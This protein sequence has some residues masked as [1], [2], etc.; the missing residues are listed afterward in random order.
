MSS[1]GEQKDVEF[2]KELEDA[3]ADNTKVVEFYGNHAKDYN[4]T[5]H[6]MGY[7]KC[8]DRLASLLKEHLGRALFMYLFLF[9]KH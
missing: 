6:L 4:D 2:F 9:F 5:L 3:R 1:A 8:T 7:N